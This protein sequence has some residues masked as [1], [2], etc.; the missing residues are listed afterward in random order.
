MSGGVRRII[1]AAAGLACSAVGFPA[2]EPPGRPPAVV[3]AE[4]L[5]EWDARFRLSDGWVGGD[6]AYS[7]PVSDTRALWFFGDTWVGSVRGGKRV[8][9]AMANN[10]AAVQDG[11]GDKATLTFAVRKDAASGKPAAIFAPPDGKGWFWPLGG[12]HLAGKLHV[13]LVQVEKTAEPGAF[14]FRLVGQWLGVVAN[15][16]DEPT[17]WKAEY[18]QLPFATFGPE[19]HVS[20]GSAALAAGEFVYVYGYEE[21]PGKPFRARRMLAARAPAGKLAEFS[22]W[23]FF[24][25]GEWKPGVKDATPL[26]DNVAVEFSVSRVPGLKKYA[27]VYTE[28]GIGERVVG[29]FAERP[30]GPWSEPVVLYRCPEMKRDKKVFTYAAKA[31]PHLAAGENELVVSYCV[32]SFELAPVINDAT[33]YWPTFVRVVLK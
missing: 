9:V 13:F 20:F 11:T 4:S 15:P 18:R 32:N 12:I 16:G 22:E 33:L 10:T 7:V 25:N 21:K 30:E 26:A 8:G 5:P 24:S 28:N 2:D 6:G 17:A 27:A 23:R 1:L 31:H 14:G 19:R 29:R 3:K